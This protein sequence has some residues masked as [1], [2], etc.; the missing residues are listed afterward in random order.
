MIDT[1]E[2]ANLAQVLGVSLQMLENL[3]SPT[4]IL[5]RPIGRIMIY[6]LNKKGFP[7]IKTSFTWGVGRPE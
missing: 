3:M 5:A 2:S 6:I 4:W 1:S 7:K